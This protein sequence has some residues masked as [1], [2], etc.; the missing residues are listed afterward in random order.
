MKFLRTLS[1]LLQTP[2]IFFRNLSYEDQ[3]KHWTIAITVYYFNLQHFA[4]ESSGMDLFP[5]TLSL[6]HILVYLYHSFII[7]II[8][9]L[10]II[11]L[12]LYLL[13]VVVGNLFRF[14][15]ASLDV[16][17]YMSDWVQIET[18]KYFTKF[19]KGYLSFW[20]P[21]WLRERFF[22]SFEKIEQKY[23]LDGYYQKLTIGEE[24]QFPERVFKYWW[25]KTDVDWFD[26]SNPRLIS[27]MKNYPKL[28]EEHR[29]EILERMATHLDNPIEH[30]R[31]VRLNQNKWLAKL[32]RIEQDRLR[33]RW[34][35][36][37]EE[38]EIQMKQM[39]E[40]LKEDAKKAW[41]S[42][43]TEVKE[44]SARAY[45]KMME[46][47]EEIVK[48]I[49]DAADRKI[50]LRKEREFRIEQG[51]PVE[52]QTV[53][54]RE[55]KTSER[56]E[57]LNRIDAPRREWV[58][59]RKNTFK[60]RL[61]VE[62][63]GDGE[64]RWK[65]RY[66]DKSDLQM[67]GFERTVFDTQIP[68]SAEIR[69]IL[70]LY[71]FVMYILLFIYFALIYAVIFVGLKVVTG[72]MNLQ[73]EKPTDYGD[74]KWRK[75]GKQAEK[76]I[77]NISKRFIEVKTVWKEDTLLKITEDIPVLHNF[78]KEMTDLVHMYR[79]TDF[80]KYRACVGGEIYWVYL[81][82]L[83][84][85]WTTLP[86]IVLILVSLPSFTLALSLD[87]AHKPQNWIKV[88]GSQW[89]WVY[90]YGNFAEIGEEPSISLLFSNIVQ[91]DDLRDPALR[92]L[93]VDGI[94]SLPVNR[95]TRLLVTS[96][97]VIH[98]FAVPALGLKIDA[99]PGRINSVTI[100]P[101]KVGVYYGQ[102]SEI[103]G[104]NHAFMPICVEVIPA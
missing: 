41:E 66:L 22:N 97:D 72:G 103:C 14:C 65:S 48:H 4:W 82:S 26:E 67:S 69:S 42:I 15:Q 43:P 104:V 19:S 93:E 84:A 47:E 78:V 64:I 35:T 51:I 76:Y 54:Q 39:A 13:L 100:L 18:Y 24:T 20:Q 73:L 40:R 36:A 88:N 95:F 59:S 89:F 55:K 79:K 74:S 75:A 85:I 62:I 102:C 31:L 91:G 94:I 61:P 28:V 70:E 98:S 6:S 21:D 25:V 68:C 37:K 12:S 90:E 96:T 44:S 86:C 53:L 34:K 30:E 5:Y 2:Y 50:A 58:A 7:L 3:V 99:C 52:P 32:A 60:N 63:R 56:A 80:G 23:N 46:K 71:G 33:N 49:A 29:N 77:N 17:L 101:T 27:L 1:N 83:E 57:W 10:V 87:E 16:W 81:S 9:P 8:P 45:A 92:L 38:S 11:A